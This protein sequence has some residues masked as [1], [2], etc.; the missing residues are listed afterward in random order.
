M[1]LAANYILIVQLT[2]R[3]PNDSYLVARAIQILFRRRLMIERSVNYRV[4]TV[5]NG[6]TTTS[7]AESLGMYIPSPSLRIN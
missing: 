4:K 2:N 3:L 6:E 7:L 5:D 1:F